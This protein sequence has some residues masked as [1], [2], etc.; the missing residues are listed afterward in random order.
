MIYPNNDLGHQEIIEV[1]E[2]EFRDNDR[3]NIFP[4][5]RF[6]YF[7]RLLKDARFIIGNSSAGIREAPFFGVPAVDI[8]TRQNGRASGEMIIHCDNSEKSILTAL[9]KARKFSQS[10]HPVSKAFGSGDS[11]HR[12]KRVVDSPEFWDLSIQKTFWEDKNA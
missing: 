2:D 7:L 5:L 8:G 1:F 6:E 11:N 9:N 4:S 10:K 3:I 12:F